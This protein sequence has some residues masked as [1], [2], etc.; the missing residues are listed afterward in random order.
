MPK[1]AKRQLVGIK[2]EATQGT[3][4]ACGVTDFI[5]VQ[6]ANIDVKV[7][8]IPRDVSR[9]YID[10]VPNFVGKRSV[11]IKFKT[12]AKWGG[13]SSAT[14]T[15]YNPLSAALVACGMSGGYQGGNVVFTT[16]ST[17]PGV[18]Y[19]GPGKSVSIEIWK[20]GIKHVAPGAL[21]SWKLIQEAGK[22]AFF[23]FSFKGLYNEPTDA[24]H[25]AATP[26]T[27]DPPLVQSATLSMQGYI[28]VATKVEID[29]GAKV[30]ERADVTATGG[31]TGFMVTLFEPKGSV[32]PEAPTIAAHNFF[33]RLANG[34]T[35]SFNSS[36]GTVA[37]NII[38]VSAA[39]VQYDAVN[40][41]SREDLLTYD[42][43]ISFGSYAG[44]DSVVVKFS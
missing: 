17:A 7:E 21:G 12:E 41:G 42:V 36:I 38:S 13:G 34:T 24:S 2:Q 23:E 14:G 19:V 1:L 32:D 20:D 16:S 22:V 35:G 11:E 9:N 8:K 30:V 27:T 33:N 40:Y 25:P 26:N 43:P 10:P 39:T 15:P 37:G 29:L 18:T 5:W 4:V 6:D 3:A 28:P 31:L 44:N